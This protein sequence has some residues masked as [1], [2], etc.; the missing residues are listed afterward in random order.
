MLSSLKYDVN[1]GEESINSLKEYS[2][3]YYNIDQVITVIKSI[4][5]WLVKVDITSAFF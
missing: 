5:I 2:L 3:H 1:P 4:G